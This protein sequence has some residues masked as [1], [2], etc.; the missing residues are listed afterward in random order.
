MKKEQSKGQ[1][2]IDRENGDSIK[3]YAI[4]CA[5]GILI[6]FVPPVLSARSSEEAFAYGPFMLPVFGY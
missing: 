4:I 2:Q 6:S 1:K 5:V 3:F